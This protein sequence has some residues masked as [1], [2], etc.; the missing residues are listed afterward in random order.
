MENFDDRMK[1]A[2]NLPTAA[3]EKERVNRE[4]AAREA[5]AAD[6]PRREALK[7]Q[8]QTT[9]FGHARHVADRIAPLAKQ[10]S[11]SLEPHAVY[12]NREFIDEFAY[13]LVGIDRQK[14]RSTPLSFFLPLDGVAMA[15]T[16]ELMMRPPPIPAKVDLV[17][18]GFQ[19]PNLH[20]A[21][22]DLFEAYVRSA[23]EGF[24]QS[25]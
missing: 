19:Q 9:I 18:L 4:A 14:R 17:S 13:S 22:Q 15:G 7:Q 1:R 16:R 3:E 8:F 21:I 12:P 25:K 24:R 20:E 6:M 5:L 23:A 10:A 2:L 11:L